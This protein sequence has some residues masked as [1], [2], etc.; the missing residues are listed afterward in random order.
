M[1]AKKVAKRPHLKDLFRTGKLISIAGTLEDGTA[2][3][4]EIWIQKPQA[5]QNDEASTMARAKQ[6]RRRAKFRNPEADEYQ[7]FSGNVDEL[8]KE[9]VLVELLRI[10][11]QKLHQQAYQEVLHDSDNPDKP[12]WGEGGQDYVDLLEAV[13]QRYNEIREHNAG[14]DDTELGIKLETDEELIRLNAQMDEFQAEVKAKLDVLLRAQETSLKKLSVEVL[15]KKL[16]DKLIDMDVNL[17]YYQEYRMQMLFYACRDPDDHSQP[18]FEEIGEIWEL[19]ELVRS[20]LFAEYDAID[21]G[22]DDL[23]NSLSPLLS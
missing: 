17:H 10:E 3:E 18:Y 2:A 8:S 11:N 1:A 23:K 5:W 16:L 9:E 19:P 20:K 13:Q 6:A 21:Q 15:R 4:S 7:V 14:I 22:I 12:K